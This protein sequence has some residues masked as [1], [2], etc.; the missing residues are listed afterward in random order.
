VP[1]TNADLC[2]T[3]TPLPLRS[4][5]YADNALPFFYDDSGKWDYSSPPSPDIVIIL[6]GPND[7]GAS[8]GNKVNWSEG[9]SE[10]TAK[11]YTAI[12]HNN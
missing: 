8:N 9:L 2:D 11:C 5:Q 12:L 4:L 3:L 10:A 1:S 6:L 7:C